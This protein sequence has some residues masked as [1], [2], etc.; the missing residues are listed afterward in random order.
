[1]GWIDRILGWWAGK[2][3]PYAVSSWRELVHKIG[4]RVN[5][6]DT[7]YD[8]VWSLV[9]AAQ[10][11]GEL[12]E[13]DRNAEEPEE[14][15]IAWLAECHGVGPSY[16]LRN[17]F[18]LMMG[19]NAIKGRADL[20]H[21]FGAQDAADVILPVADL[22]RRPIR[23]LDLLAYV[24]EVL[25]CDVE[26]GKVNEAISHHAPSLSRSKRQQFASVNINLMGD[27][28]SS[29][30]HKMGQG[31]DQSGVPPLVK[32]NL[33][34]LDAHLLDF[35]IGDGEGYLRKLR[36]RVV[37]RVKQLDTTRRVHPLIVYRGGSDEETYYGLLDRLEPIFSKHTNGEIKGM[38]DGIHADYRK[39][40]YS[41][42]NLR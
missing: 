18:M 22:F 20:F 15:F 6:E 9:H 23:L 12:G 11:K 42:E 34:Q 1:M 39:L 38:C 2:P 13:I 4:F 25:G 33:R 16:P 31:I 8:Q 41:T 14:P 37:N 27:H 17:Q 19:T 36:S 10:G 29:K 5:E 35:P 21:A 32:E 3:E 7:V 28:L 30:R 40:F 24:L 26:K